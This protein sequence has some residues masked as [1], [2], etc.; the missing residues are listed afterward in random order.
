MPALTS[1]AY[2]DA[3]AV[4]MALLRDIAPTV[5]ALPNDFSPPIIVVKRVG[6]QPDPDDINGYPVLLV[7]VYGVDYHSAQ[8][9]M[10]Q[11]QVRILNSPLT[12]VP[13]VDD[14]G[15]VT[16]TVLVDSAGIHVGEVELPDVYPDDRRITAT[17]QF[18]WRRQFLAG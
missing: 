4:V 9:L 10:A 3:N 18:G 15:N 7:Q 2:P 5:L 14:T 17:Y 16:A 8:G 11:V 6:G 12:A 1:M 13:L